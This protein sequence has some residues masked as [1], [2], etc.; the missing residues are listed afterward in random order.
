M[1][2]KILPIKTK[3]NNVCLKKINSKIN[4]KLPKLHLSWLLVG[5]R[6]SGK[7]NLLVN[8]LTRKEFYKNIFKPQDIILISPSIGLDETLDLIDTPWKFRE[9]DELLIQD[10]ID[11][12][13]MIIDLYGKERCK[14]L[15]LI[16]D[17]CITEGAF[18]FNGILEHLFYRS[19]HYNLS[20][21]ITSQKYSALSR[22]IRVNSVQ[23][24]FFEPVN[25][26]ELEWLV[27]THSNKFNKKKFYNMAKFCFKSKYNFLHID[28]GKDKDNRYMLNFNK[29]LNINDFD[30]DD[31]KE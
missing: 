8:L 16:L 31:N 4:D 12:Q 22:G 29:T 30:K 27:E 19:R 14:Q 5:S 28:Y 10:I 6:G 20:L 23:Q 9:F 17:D 15:L 7:T 3:S 21:I 1:E 2:L 25:E 11:Q 13:K 18:R 24:T 26:S